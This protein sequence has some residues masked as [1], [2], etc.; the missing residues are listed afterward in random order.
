[1]G[2]SERRAL[3]AVLVLGMACRSVPPGSL[4][5][6]TPVD[7][8]RAG[9]EVAPAPVTDEPPPAEIEPMAEPPLDRAKLDPRLKQEI[10]LHAEAATLQQIILTL[11]KQAGANVSVEKDVVGETSVHFV[12]I[13]LVDAVQQLLQPFGYGLRVDGAFIH[14]FKPTLVTR[15]YQVNFP[16]A[17]RKGTLRVTVSDRVIA[18]SAQIPGA[19][20]ATQGDT[21]SSTSIETTVQVNVWRDIAVGLRAIVLAKEGVEQIGGAGDAEGQGV[22]AYGDKEGRAIVVNPAAGTVQV[23][24]QPTLHEAVR[25]YLLTVQRSLQQQVIIEARVLEITLND[26]FQAGV[27][28]THLLSVG[29]AFWRF[30]QGVAVP[31]VEQIALTG[32]PGGLSVYGTYGFDEGQV[33]GLV[34][35]LAAAGRVDVVSAPRI[36]VTN[37][38]KAVVKVVK[39]RIFFLAQA[40]PTV[41]GTGGTVTGGRQFLPMVV[42]EGIVFDVT[43][44]IGTDGWVTLNLHPSFAEVS[45]VVFTPNR[46][47]GSLPE[48]SRREFDTV[49]RVRNGHTVVIGGLMSEKTEVLEDGVP[50]LKDLWL[51]GY[52]FRQTR[53]ITRK[54]ELVVLVTP[55]VQTAVSHAATTRRAIDGL[56]EPTAPRPLPVEPGR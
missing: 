3:C 5:H 8:W 16:Q 40:Q 9:A 52:L 41:V 53:R 33:A 20:G 19:V 54:A 2:T 1:M 11:A 4:S 37:N 10:S 22:I 46:E 30:S 39:E 48:M 26:E 36:A 35:A 18:A 27:D 47:D 49:V 31:P 15:L 12:K 28:L 44:Q 7:A 6:P 29:K 14:V 32:A 17:T 34:K 24:A 25:Q 45:G 13:S 50:F 43:P 21:G 23:R 38:Q 42:N 56:K 55:Q 51:L